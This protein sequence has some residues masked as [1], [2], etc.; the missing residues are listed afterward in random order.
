M[1]A[2]AMIGSGLLSRQEADQRPRGIARGGR[3]PGRECDGAGKFAR[4]RHEIDPGDGVYLMRE[5]HRQ[6][7]FAAR[8]RR[9]IERAA[10][11]DQLR[12]KLVGDPEMAQHLGEMHA[13][14]PAAVGIGDHDRAHAEQ[15]VAEHVGRADIGPRGAGPHRHAD[16]GTGDRDNRT[17]I[18]PAEPRQFRERR[19]RK[20]RQIERLAGEDPLAHLAGLAETARRGGYRSLPKSAAPGRP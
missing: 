10:G 3:K 6:I 19:R 15:P 11:Q 18:D 2:A 8:H 16:F 20:Q 1:P 13:A 14:D 9:R 4:H 17:G 5:L 12:R 7:G